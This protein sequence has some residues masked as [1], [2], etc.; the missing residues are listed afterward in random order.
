MSAEC[1]DPATWRGLAPEFQVA[2][3]AVMAARRD[4]LDP[5]YAI[6]LVLALAA[7]DLGKPIVSLETPESQIA[8]LRAADARGDD[9][10]RRRAASTSSKP[11]A[12]GRCSSRLA[13]AWTDG[14]LADARRLRALVRVP[15]QRRRA[16]V[17]EAPARR[18]QPGAGR[19]R[20]T[21]SIASGRAVFA[22]V[23]SLHMIGP[24]GLAGAAA[25]SAASRSSA[26][27]CRGPLTR[28]TVGPRR[29][30]ARQSGDNGTHI[31]E[32]TR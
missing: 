7:R 18:P 2:S 29:A 3:L 28:L 26:C 12:P 4:G 1:I 8:A 10:V 11:A 25:R 13:E 17:D 24:S 30:K 15:A 6:D 5:A 20:S 9:R 22:A 21:R 27:R 19:R 31:T 14:D 16:R 32:E 23:G